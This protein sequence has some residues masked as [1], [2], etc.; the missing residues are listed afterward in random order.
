MFPLKQIVHGTE[1]MNDMQK[2]S[3]SG[4]RNQPDD[5]EKS[6]KTLV[7][8]SFSR[9]TKFWCLFSSYL[10]YNKTITVFI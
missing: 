10:F 7:V 9:K 5:L 2:S 4:Q 6:N 8:S 3:S 1:A